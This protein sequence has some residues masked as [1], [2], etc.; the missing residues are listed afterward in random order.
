MTKKAALD[1]ILDTWDEDTKIDR[2]ELGDAS[3]DIP[4]LHSK[5]LR[6][7]TS[8]KLKLKLLEAESKALKLEKH[9]FYTQGESPETRAKGWKMPSRGVILVKDIPLYMEA[10]PHLI[11]MNLRVAYQAEIVSAIELIMKSIHGRNWEVRAA[12]DWIKFTSGIG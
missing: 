8:E 11:E 2:T 5:W 4:K 1:E 9:E 3:L 10:D 12:I 7:L 6:R